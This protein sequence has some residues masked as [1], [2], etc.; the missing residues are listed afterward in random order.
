MSKLI[1]KINLLEFTLYHPF[2]K[3]SHIQIIDDIFSYSLDNLK[4]GKSTIV[5][6]E[7]FDSNDMIELIK[8]LNKLD[9]KNWKKNYVSYKIPNSIE[10]NLILLYNDNKTVFEYY[11][12]NEFPIPHKIS[13]PFHPL[14]STSYTP[15]FILLLRSL[16]KFLGKRTFFK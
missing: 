5:K 9:L 10:W 12:S 15:E 8:N 16:N 1:K 11:G 6:F 4:T 14:S 13:S 7:K 2:K 3:K